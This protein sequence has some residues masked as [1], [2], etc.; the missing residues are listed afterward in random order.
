MLES[1]RLTGPLVHIYYIVH[2][3]SPPDGTLGRPHPL[4]S[5]RT[6]VDS[7]CREEADPL[8]AL[9]RSELRQ[10]ALVDAHASQQA[11]RTALGLTDFIIRPR[12]GALKR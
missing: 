12:E 7:A 1:L 9:Q 6:L 10:A 11:A 5:L 8:R 4:R 3:E 2:H